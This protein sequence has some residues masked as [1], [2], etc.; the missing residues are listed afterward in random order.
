VLPALWLALAMRWGLDWPLQ[1][2][3]ERVL[4]LCW[5]TPDSLLRVM[6]AR[7]SVLPLG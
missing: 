6:L 7:A 5:Q 4:T 1:A 2:P 3:P